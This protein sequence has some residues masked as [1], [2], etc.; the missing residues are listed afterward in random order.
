M[1]SVKDYISLPSGNHI[2]IIGL[3]TWDLVEDELKQALNEALSIGYRHIDTSYMH[4]NESTIGCVIRDWLESK[5]LKRK[6]LFVTSKVKYKEIE[7]KTK[8]F[9][10]RFFFSFHQQECRRMQKE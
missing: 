4:G 10:C 5:R 3:G 6:D 8:S 7:L 2:P 9:A 1:T